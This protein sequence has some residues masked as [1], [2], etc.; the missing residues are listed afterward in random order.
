ML[1][2]P[3]LRYRVYPLGYKLASHSHSATAPKSQRNSQPSL[4]I[5]HSQMDSTDINRLV[6]LLKIE[7]R[8]DWIDS[9]LSIDINE[10]FI[11]SK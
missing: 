10:I 3:F 8:R 11:L 6:S 5:V 9:F 7:N 2:A 4:G 1:F